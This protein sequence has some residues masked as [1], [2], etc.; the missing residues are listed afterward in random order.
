[1][2]KRSYRHSHASVRLP[3]H[4]LDDI[5]LKPKGVST[6]QHGVSRHSGEHFCLAW[7]MFELRSHDISTYVLMLA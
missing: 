4:T 2:T 5:T 1:M 7:C 6:L 3:P